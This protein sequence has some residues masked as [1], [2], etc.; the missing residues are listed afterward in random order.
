MIL[1]KIAVGL[2]LLR[3]ATSRKQ[4][5]FLYACTSSCV[6]VGLFYWFLIL[7]QCRPVSYWWNLDTGAHGECISIE[8][9]LDSSYVAAGLNVWSDLTFAVI[10]M[11]MVYSTK[12]NT[13]TMWSVIFA[14]FLGTMYV[15]CVPSPPDI[16]VA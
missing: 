2:F 4:T 14:I 16:S 1:L 13:R 7:F 15:T 12:M 3:F 11:I 6:V 5:W 9:L 10:P 8:F